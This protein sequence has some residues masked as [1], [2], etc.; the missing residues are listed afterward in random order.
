MSERK[1]AWTLCAALQ[2]RMKSVEIS[3]SVIR[4]H[5]RALE[6][7][8]I[9]PDLR[10]LKTCVGKQRMDCR[11]Q[12]GVREATREAVAVVQQ[13]GDG[14]LGLHSVLTQKNLD[15]SGKSTVQDLRRTHHLS[16]QVDMKHLQALS[17]PT[18]HVCVQS[19]CPLFPFKLF[20]KTRFPFRKVHQS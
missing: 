15:H 4:S 6:R 2:V 12:S 9:E 14:G 11:G 16:E 19:V 3:L 1:I 5:W 13:R 10:S 7:E 17:H 8:I 20:I 18:E